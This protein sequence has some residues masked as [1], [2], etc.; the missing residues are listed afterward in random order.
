MLNDPVGILRIVFGNERFNAGRIKDGHVCFCRVNRL[1][2]GL[3]KINKV[4]ECKLQVIPK[5]LFEAGD[6]GSIRDF[7]KTTE[8]AEWV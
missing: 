6:Y 2:D 5:V 3:G 8:L 7:G 4:V 1:A